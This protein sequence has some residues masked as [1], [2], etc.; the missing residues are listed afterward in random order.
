MNHSDSSEHRLNE[1]N[2]YLRLKRFS[3]VVIATDLE[4]SEES[5]LGRQ[6]ARLREAISGR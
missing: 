1:G 5:A 2:Y 3:N 4:T 6:V